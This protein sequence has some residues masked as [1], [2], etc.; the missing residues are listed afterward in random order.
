MKRSQLERLQAEWYTKLRKD[1][2][3]DI[4]D[5]QGRLKSWTISSK[6]ACKQWSMKSSTYHE[7][8]ITKQVAR[9]EYFRLAGHFLFDHDFH[10]PL[11]RDVWAAHA[12]GYG[13]LK[14]YRLVKETYR[15]LKL[16]T[17]RRIIVELI[18]AMKRLYLVK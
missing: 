9:E 1:G 4:E 2:F 12:L 11:E 3:K 10:S 5:A 18:R 15:D 13:R 16:G 7:Q 17:C 14:V 8:V 6:A